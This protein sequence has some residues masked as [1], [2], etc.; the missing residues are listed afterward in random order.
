[1]LKKKQFLT[2]EPALSFNE[3][4]LIGLLRVFYQFSY[5][6]EYS[7]LHLYLFS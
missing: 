2:S 4:Q 7:V 5:S 6:D 3:S 1:M